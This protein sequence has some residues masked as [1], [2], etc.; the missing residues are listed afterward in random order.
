MKMAKKILAFVLSASFILTCAGGA[1]AEMLPAA[2]PE[3]IPGYQASAAAPAGQEAAKAEAE[4]QPAAPEAQPAAAIGSQPA[5]A[6]AQPAAATPAVPTLW[7]FRIIIDNVEYQFPVTVSELIEKGWETTGNLEQKTGAFNLAPDKTFTYKKMPVV[8]YVGNPTRK[9]CSLKECKVYGFE[10]MLYDAEQAGLAVTY[11]QTLDLMNAKHADVKALYGEPD[12]G[13]SRR[14]N[15][16][17]Y[18]YDSYVSPESTEKSADFYRFYYVDG[19]DFVSVCAFY[20]MKGFADECGKSVRAAKAA[21]EKAEKTAAVK[22]ANQEEKS[23][24]QKSD[25]S[26]QTAKTSKSGKTYDNSKNYTV[27]YSNDIYQVPSTV[28]A[29]WG[30]DV[31]QDDD[32]FRLTVEDDDGEIYDD[33]LDDFLYDFAEEDWYDD[34]DI[35]FDDEIW[36]L[37]NDDTISDEEW[38]ERY[39]YLVDNGYLDEDYEEEDGWYFDEDTGEWYFDEDYYDDEDLFEDE[40]LYEDEE[41]FEDEDL[42]GD[43]EYYDEEYYDEDYY[44]DEYYDDDEWYYEDEYYDDAGYY[45]DEEYYGEDW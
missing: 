23:T 41:L 38:I 10:F 39:N 2:S 11:P 4:G 13:K 31:P 36:A 45:D 35:W 19:N 27:E 26:K 6:E 14:D 16:N 32:R 20:M 7:D 8:L 37:L 24:G 18:E 34:E 42:Y 29:F 21:K 12:A 44:D 17:G 22:T 33:Y 25:T 28:V 1:S 3:E 30:K 9:E 40:D 43:E 5:A 15:E